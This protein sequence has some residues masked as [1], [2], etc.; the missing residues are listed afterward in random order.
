MASTMAETARSGTDAAKQHA[1]FIQN[2]LDRGFSQAQVA[3]A[4]G[5]TESYVSQLCTQFKL[6]PAP[7]Q[8]FSKH[9]ELYEA[10]ELAALKRLKNTI[11]FEP[12]LGAVALA[13]IAATLN[14]TKRRSQNEAPAPVQQTVLTLTMP[15]TFAAQFVFN[16]SNE[17]IAVQSEDGM[18]VLATA[19]S[20][21]VAEMATSMLPQLGST[22]HAK[23]ISTEDL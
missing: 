6:A 12:E 14:G 23:A 11:E 7:Q 22:S 16:G 18:R 20:K 8:R 15:V 13:K 21:Q 19:S 4:L 5:V 9:D 3:D 10:T 1:Q 2:A 17:A